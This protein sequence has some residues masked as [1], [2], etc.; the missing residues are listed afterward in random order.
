VNKVR[1]KK[2]FGQHFLIDLSVAERLAALVA[3][4][5]ITQILEVGP[6]TGVLTQFLLKNTPSNLK[7]V[8]IDAESVTFLHQHFKDLGHHIIEA[9]FLKL[10]LEQ[11]FEG[12]FI[13]VGNYPY[14]ISTQIVFKILEHRDKIPFMAGMFQLEVAK[15][16]VSK[17][18]TKDYGILSVLTQA[19][20]DVHLEFTVEP[21]AFNPPPKVRS[22][23]IT[24]RLKSNSNLG[25]NEALFFQVVKT[26]FGQRRKMLS[27]PLGRFNVPKELLLQ[28]RFAKL[29]AENLTV[30]DFVE[31][32][33]FIEQNRN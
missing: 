11:I 8:E 28:N 33:N 29:R 25:C 9:D 30:E 6:G 26:G 5:P 19:F 4:E 17:K 32:T 15:R 20:F 27:N 23:V 10:N 2:K 1:P 13:L 22:A 24:C 14:N 12:P 31:L 7:V 21:G 3:K 16:I 18:D